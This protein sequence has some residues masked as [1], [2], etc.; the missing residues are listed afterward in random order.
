LAT[1]KHSL[2]RA[3]NLVPVI[4]QAE[5]GDEMLPVIRSQAVGLRRYIV[6][7]RIERGV[8][9]CMVSSSLLRTIAL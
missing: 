6:D 4:E 3:R 1:L 5:M 8:G 9:L 2:A 7:I